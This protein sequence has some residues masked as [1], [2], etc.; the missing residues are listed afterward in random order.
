MRQ[1]RIRKAAGADF[2]TICVIYASAREYMKAAG[3]PN[4]WKDEY[5]PLSLIEADISSAACHVVGDEDGIHGVFALITGGDPLY[6]DIRCRS[7]PDSGPYLAV[8]RVASDGSRRGVFRAI[9]DHCKSLGMNIRIDTH[10]DNAVMLRHI[11]AAGFRRCGIIDLPDGS[12]RI[13]FQWTCGG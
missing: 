7:W 10:S 6:S 1:M 5:P 9:S 2:R 12:E 13:D 3:N 8:H 4:Q 11:E